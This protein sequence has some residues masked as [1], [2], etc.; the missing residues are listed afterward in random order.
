MNSEMS[1]DIG[2]PFQMDNNICTTIK[3]MFCLEK[4]NKST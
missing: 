3:K 1:Y 2:D 4:Y